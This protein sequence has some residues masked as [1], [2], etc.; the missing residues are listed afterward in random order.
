MTKVALGVLDS[1]ASMGTAAHIAP[2]AESVGYQR[3]WFTEHQPQASPLLPAALLLGLT[4][5]LRVGTAGILVGYH[6]VYRVA[7]DFRFLE[8][9]FPGRVDAGFCGGHVAD[10]ELEPLRPHKGR[11]SLGELEERATTF[12]GLIRDDLPADHRWAGARQISRG[13]SAT[14]WSLGTS[15]GGARFAAK[16][17][18]RYAHSLFHRQSQDRT[19]A[20]EQYRAQF[21]GRAEDCRVALA[22]SGV[23][24]ATDEEA[25]R[26]RTV[27]RPIFA[28][29]NIVGGVQQCA[30]RLGQLFRRY[31]MD[32]LV[33]IDVCKDFD[34]K[35]IS[36]E[37]MA[38]AARAAFGT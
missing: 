7:Q 9:V 13:A 8:Q 23:C 6:D 30:D 22:V 26:L 37:L 33:F 18:V 1:D 5:S 31:G 28:T 14:P 15:E 20:I 10:E 11:P 16:L 36:Y 12:V 2:L 17:G 27:Y 29:A 25:H 4:E 35:L 19:E 38:Q 3:Y 32:D 24:A 34:A 21:R